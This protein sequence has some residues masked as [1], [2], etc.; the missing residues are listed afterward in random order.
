M[1]GGSDGW[2]GKRCL[3]TGSSYSSL[4]SL[5]YM[6]MVAWDGGE[7]DGEVVG[8]LVTVRGKRQLMICVM[9]RRW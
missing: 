1:K 5:R 8:R 6:A 2:G 4:F 7:G 3:A 9:G